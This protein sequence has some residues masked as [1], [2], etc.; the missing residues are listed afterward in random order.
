MVKLQ[1]TIDDGPQPVKGVLIPILDEIDSR[2]IKAAFFVIGEEVVGTHSTIAEISRRGHI[3]GN[4]SWNHLEPSTSRYTDNDI[5]NQFKKTHDEVK[6]AGYTMLHWRAPRL[7]QIDRLERILVHDKKL[8]TFSHT[9]IHADSQDAIKAKTAGKMIKNIE[10]DLKKYKDNTKSY[11]LLFH[12]KSTTAS[13]LKEVLDHLIK[14]GHK[15]VDF[16]QSR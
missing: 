15:L 10:A 1:L 12:V 2:N 8:Y 7:Q 9:D 3:I 5:Y 13:A 11:R 4:H 16:S 14:K 6:S